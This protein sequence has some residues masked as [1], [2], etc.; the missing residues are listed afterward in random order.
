MSIFEKFIIHLLLGI[1][2]HVCNSR[3]W[4]AK[5]KRNEFKARL[6]YRI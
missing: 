2:A 6:V 4:K 5:G 3:T 1:V